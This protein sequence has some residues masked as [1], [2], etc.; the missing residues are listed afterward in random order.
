MVD[1]KVLKYALDTLSSSWE[2]LVLFLIPIGG[3]IPAGVLLA[4]AKGLR[5][6]V[7]AALYLISDV[8]LAMIFEPLMLGLI[9]VARKSLALTKITAAFRDSVKKTTASYGTELGPLSL[10]LIAFGA[11][12]MTGR[13]AGKSAGYGFV[14]GWVFAIAGDMIFFGVLMVSTLWLN[15]ILGDGTI[16]TFVIVAFMFVIPIGIRKIRERWQ[17]SKHQHETDARG[18]R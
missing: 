5:W 1:P 14:W 10:I 6:F 8:I 3:G 15:G 13:A 12:P 9:K 16:T 18:G 11:D 4:K 2:V 7:T 17:S